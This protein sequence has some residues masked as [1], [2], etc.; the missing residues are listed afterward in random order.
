MGNA[1]SNSKLFPVRNHTVKLNYN[2]TPLLHSTNE[3]KRIIFAYLLTEIRLATTVAALILQY[4]CF[5]RHLADSKYHL[6]S[7]F[8][9]RAWIILSARWCPWVQCC[10]FFSLF[11]LVANIACRRRVR[12]VKSELGIFLDWPQCKTAADSSGSRQ[13]TEISVFHGFTN[14]FV[15]TGFVLYLEIRIMSSLMLFVLMITLINGSSGIDDS[16][17]WVLFLPFM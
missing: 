2:K 17:R 6:Y 4:P 16:E 7:P 9:N 13:I 15:L 10:Y 11:W 1:V 8:P 14:W 12:A 5:N 3:R